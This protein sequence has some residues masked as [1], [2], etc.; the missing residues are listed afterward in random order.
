MVVCIGRAD[1][2]M[3]IWHAGNFQAGLSPD[4]ES[5][6]VLGAYPSSSST[7]EVV[8]KFLRGLQVTLHLECVCSKAEN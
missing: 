8:D 2:A 6:S 4:L 1:Q 7:H 3:L 5:Y